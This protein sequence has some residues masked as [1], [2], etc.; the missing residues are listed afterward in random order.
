MH[1]SPLDN[2]TVRASAGAR[3]QRFYFRE[4]VATTHILRLGRRAGCNL[5]RAVIEACAGFDTGRSHSLSKGS[6]VQL[7]RACVS[8]LAGET[9]GSEQ[10]R[11]NALIARRLW[12]ARKS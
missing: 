10:Q 4:R 11:A 2:E 1:I 5:L 12:P 3:L 6:R 7:P 8:M 9:P